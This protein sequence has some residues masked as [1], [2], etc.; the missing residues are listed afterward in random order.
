MTTAVAPWSLTE[1]AS[2]QHLNTFHVTAHAPRLLRI[3]D[4]AGRRRCW[5]WAAAATC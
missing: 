2:L 5:C 4:P 3:A 1:N